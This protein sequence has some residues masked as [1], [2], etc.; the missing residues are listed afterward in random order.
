MAG[1]AANLLRLAAEHRVSGLVVGLPLSLDGSEGPQAD[2]TRAWAEAM[3]RLTGL[4]LSYQDERR[5]SQDAE[6]RMG[7]PARGRSGGAPSAA[8]M[9]AYRARV[10]REAACAILQAALDARHGLTA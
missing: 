2:V 6:Q 7:A 1:D 10:D 4:P 3:A 9:R 5:T 8:A